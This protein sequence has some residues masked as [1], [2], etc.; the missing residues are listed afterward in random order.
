M[1]ENMTLFGGFATEAWE[2]FG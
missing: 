1:W 2:K